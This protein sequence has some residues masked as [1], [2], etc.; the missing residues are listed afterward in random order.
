MKTPNNPKNEI[1]KPTLKPKT[2]QE[3]SVNVELTYDNDYLFD[4]YDKLD[5]KQQEELRSIYIEKN[6]AKFLENK[7]NNNNSNENNISVKISPTSDH[8]TISAKITNSKGKTVAISNEG[9][10][11]YNTQKLDNY[12]SKAVLQ[13]H[14]ND[15]KQILTGAN[16][17]HIEKLGIHLGNDSKT[18]SE[19]SSVNDIIKAKNKAGIEFDTLYTTQ[20]PKPKKTPKISLNN[21][22]KLKPKKS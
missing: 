2:N 16:A 1:S 22:Y 5:N 8:D 14:G 18:I 21:T 7:N 6:Y 12:D 13:P 15:R 19:S 9:N 20:K 3:E 4:M 10:V 17:K 11:E